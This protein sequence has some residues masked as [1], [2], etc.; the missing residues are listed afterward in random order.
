MTTIARR[1]PRQVRGQVMVMFALMVTILI[2][3]TALAIDVSHL[4]SERRAAQNAADA[5]AMAVGKALARNLGSTG[6]V[7]TQS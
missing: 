1:P 7:V 3:F 6:A 4:L 5:A 2:G